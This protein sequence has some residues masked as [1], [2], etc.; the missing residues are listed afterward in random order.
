MTIHKAACIC[1]PSS[2]AQGH[3]EIT[4]TNVIYKTYISV[5]QKELY[6]KKKKTY[7]NADIVP[8]APLN[9]KWTRPV[10]LV[11]VT[12]A[13]QVNTFHILNVWAL[14]ST[15]TYYKFI[16]IMFL[17]HCFHTKKETY[18]HKYFPHNANSASWINTFNKIMD[19]MTMRLLEKEIGPCLWRQIRANT[20]VNY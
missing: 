2:V 20:R 4:W 8:W 15:A 14:C 5:K 9:M 18:Y 17:S 16:H 6:L 7:F 1:K 3:G 11:S 19:L 10:S 13:K 12:F